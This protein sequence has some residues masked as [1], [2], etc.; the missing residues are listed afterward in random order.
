MRSRAILL[1]L[2]LVL[3]A[4]GQPPADA[5]FDRRVERLIRD[6]EAASFR[7]REAAARTL[8]DLRVQAEPVLTEALKRPLGADA[9]RRIV[10]M[11]AD[12][13]DR[14][15]AES[16]GWYMV[17]QGMAHAQSFKATGTTVLSLHVRV[18]LPG[19]PEQAAPLDVDIRDATMERIF[20]RGAIDPAHANPKHAWQMVSL[21][22]RAPLT[23]GTTY[24]IVFHSR[25]TEKAWN[26]NAVYKPV[27]PHGEHVGHPLKDSLFFR[28]GFKDGKSIHVGPALDAAPVQ[29]INGG[30]K[31][32]PPLLAIRQGLRLDHDAGDVPPGTLVK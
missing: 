24:R 22:H 1:V 8:W 28:L 5:E 31:K 9:R 21:T 14:Y 13:G 15:P 17:G 7:D 26:I 12:L 29:P 11:I 27:Y 30:A 25:Q 2:L 10:A 23:A 18:A 3:P 4:L 20:A 6:L 16:N 19:G 32:V